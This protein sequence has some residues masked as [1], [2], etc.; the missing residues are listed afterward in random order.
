[1][2]DKTFLPESQ[3]PKLETAARE[4]NQI[5]S[6]PKLSD[7]LFYLALHAEAEA[8]PESL[9]KPR[10]AGDILARKAGTDIQRKFLTIQFSK[11]LTAHFKKPPHNSVAARLAWRSM[12]QTSL[13]KLLSG[14]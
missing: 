14:S 8:R 5:F 7:I 2:L 10:I 3:Q 6:Y 12:I 4:L 13:Q 1:M 9:F 11:L